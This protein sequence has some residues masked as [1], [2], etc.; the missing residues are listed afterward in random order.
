[1]VLELTKEQRAFQQSV[2]E[3]AAEV[4]APRAAGLD[5]SG[6]F[7]RDVMRAA[8]GRGLLGVTIPRAGAAPG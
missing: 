6:E 8:G 2:E 7:P 3:F 4:V 5:E 1:M